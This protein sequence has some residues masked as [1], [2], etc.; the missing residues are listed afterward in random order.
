MS[1]KLSLLGLSWSC[2][3]RMQDKLEVVLKRKICQDAI[4]YVWCIHSIFCPIS[5]AKYHSNFCNL[6]RWLL[7]YI[8]G[9]YANSTSKGIESQYLLLKIHHKLMT[10]AWCNATYTP[11]KISVVLNKALFC[12]PIVLTCVLQGCTYMY[13]II[14]VRT[15]TCIYM[16]V[17]VHV[18]IC[19]HVYNYMYLSFYE[20]PK[21]YVH[22]YMYICTCNMYIHVYMLVLLLLLATNSSIHVY[23]YIAV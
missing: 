14:H 1:Q 22:T 7:E 6:G 18:Y 3:C 21:M 2:V 15:R 11:V 4:V 10:Y 23:T 19:I 13:N 12:C 9:V 17:H 5:T 8:G 16:Y 20:P